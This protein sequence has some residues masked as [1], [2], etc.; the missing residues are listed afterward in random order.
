MRSAA[1]HAAR[2][3][4]GETWAA[5]PPATLTVATPEHVLAEQRFNLLTALFT[6]QIVLIHTNKI[7]HNN[8]KICQPPRVE[9]MPMEAVVTRPHSQR[10]LQGLSGKKT[11]G[12]HPTTRR[13]QTNIKMF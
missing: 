13:T 3:P 5:T 6:T 10:I 8:N 1:M 9:T 12:D 4:G 2:V 7:L 11:P